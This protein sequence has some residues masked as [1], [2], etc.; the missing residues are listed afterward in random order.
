MIF[1]IECNNEFCLTC[2]EKNFKCVS[3][4]GTLHILDSMCY[5]PDNQMINPIEYKCQGWIFLK[6]F[7]KNIKI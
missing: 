3:C 1:F 2:G 4:K 7:F 5:C 6:Y